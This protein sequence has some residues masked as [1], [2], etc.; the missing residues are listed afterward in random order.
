MPRILFKYVLR[1]VLWPSVLALLGLTF[2]LFLAARAPGFRDENLA[3]MIMRMF[4]RPDVSNGELLFVLG[5][6]FPTLIMFILPM[7]L[8]I[9]ILIGVGRMTLD[10]EVRAMQTGGIPLYILFLPVLVVAALLSGG[11]AFMAYAPEPLLIRG[12]M[13]R[14]AKV[15]VAEF[16]TLEAGRVYDE[17]FGEDSGM[18]LYFDSRDDEENLMHGV[19]LLIDQENFR[20]SEA[21]LEAKVRYRLESRR[22]NALY[23]QGEITRE[24]KDRRLY[25]LKVAY[26]KQNPVLIF[27]SGA[28]FDADPDKG[29][30]KL[31]LYDGSMHILDSKA[32]EEEAAGTGEPV[33]GGSPEGLP[34]AGGATPVEGVVTGLPAGA[35]AGAPA[36]ES[37]PPPQAERQYVVLNFGRMRRTEYLGGFDADEN[38][39]AQTVPDLMRIME[40]APK[41]REQLR[42]KATILERFSGALQC[43]VLAFIGLPLAVSVK[44][45]GKSIG[46][47]LAFGLI[48]IYQWILRTGFTMV[49]NDHPLGVF[50]IF[51]PNLLFLTAGLF[52]WRQSLRA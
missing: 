31:D 22:L 42:A 9:G 3:F 50:V 34:G 2:I 33:A 10:L 28:S 23:E 21:T 49:E 32:E 8:L 19:T 30:V 25:D 27:A 45:S 46:I 41:E 4:F 26:K 24:E 52:L 11:V 36:A 47:I 51:L 7:A 1:E 43:F 15:L 39:R 13:K 18:N 44:P 17:I 37:G 5:S 38:R 29:E 16:S 48:L 40:E 14:I 6:V 12:S 20:Q 35:G